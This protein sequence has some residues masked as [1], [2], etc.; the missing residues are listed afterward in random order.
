VTDIE[1]IGALAASSDIGTA[2]RNV[3]KLVDGYSYSWNPVGGKEAN[4]GLINIGSDPGLAFVERITNAIDAIIEREADKSE[5]KLVRTLKSPRDAVGRLFGVKDGRLIQLTGKQRETLAADT[6]ISLLDGSNADTPTLEVRDHGVGLDPQSMPNTILSLA[7][8]NKIDKPYLA[9]A[10]GQGGSTTFAFCPGTIICSRKHHDQVGVTF[11]RYNPLDPAINKNG[12]YEYLVD[13]NGRIPEI[14]EKLFPFLT[15]VLVRH[16]DY[17]FKAYSQ[18]MTQLQKSLWSLAHTALFDPVL[19]FSIADLRAKHKEVGHRTVAG[20]FSRLEND[21]RDKVDYRQSATVTIRGLMDYGRVVVH[22]WV[23]TADSESGSAS[24]VNPAT[25]LV[26]THYGQTHGYEDRRFIIDELQLP[27]LKKH[28][29]IQ[30]ELDDLSAS[31]KRE[32]LSSTRDRLKRSALYERLMEEIAE[33]LRDDETLETIN[34]ER[35]SKV[36]QKQMGAD[37]EKIKRRFVELLERHHAGKDVPAATASEG[38]GTRKK[39]SGGTGGELL[40]LPTA[41]RPSFIKVGNKI[42]PLEIRSNRLALIMIESDAPDAYLA[43]HPAARLSIMAEPSQSL[44]VVRHTDFNGGRARLAVKLASGAV[45][46]TG[47]VNSFLLDID[48]R[49]Y[50]DKAPYEILPDV[51]EESA[52]PGGK[53]EVEAP[54]I[55]E[56]YET[57]WA[58]LDWNRESVVRVDIAQDKTTIFVNMDNRHL[59]RLLESSTYQETGITRMK[60]GFLL[61]VAFYGFLQRVATRERYNDLSVEEM[62]TYQR[63]ENDRLA[64]T[65]VSALGAAERTDTVASIA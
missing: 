33:A 12:R 17:D 47:V 45:G 62:E 20:N 2:E 39:V 28:L 37:R 16:F 6:V 40:P 49:T 1:L 61:Y 3:A 56:I 14:S 8:S 27:F 7:D 51:P 64:Q 35:R 55:V 58:D 23:I 59:R 25:P 5:E 53:S 21:R 44:E 36:L 29:I 22:Y 43:S 11:V 4:Y 26:L 65:I 34:A 38:A 57:A 9:G 13:K 46:D 54:E 63:D 52:Q 30:V 60:A 10:Y 50:S 19:P 18:K 32:L 42:R 41:D 15:G 31:A 24:Y 48:E